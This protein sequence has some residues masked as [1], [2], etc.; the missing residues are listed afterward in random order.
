MGK[1]W[2]ETVTDFIFLGFK[3][4]ADGDCSHETK[5]CLILGRKA[6]TNLDSIIKMQRHHFANRDPSS[7][8]YGFSSSHVWM[9][10][11][12][13][14]ESW[15]PKNWCFWIVVLEKTLESSFDRQ[16][17]KPVNPK[18]NQSWLFIGRTDAEAP[19][20]WSP[21][22]R[23]WLIGKDPDGGKDWS[24]EE[25]GTTEDE[26]IGWHHWLDGHEFEHALGL[27]DGLGSLVCYSPWGHKELNM[28]KQLNWLTEDLSEHVGQGPCLC[29]LPISLQPHYNSQFFS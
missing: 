16:E 22:G 20:L 4:T 25:K 6:M 10:E 29:P 1:Q 8:S 5:R 17:I 28:T 7:Q 18:G 13:H 2:K 11:L 27:G 21:D 12:D 19:I 14:K 26:I 15:A 24:Q 9:W 23:N 3:I